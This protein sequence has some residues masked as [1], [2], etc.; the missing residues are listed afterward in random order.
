MHAPNEF[1]RLQSFDRGVR[2]Y[3]RLFE[4]LGALAPAALRA[5]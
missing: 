2:A 5:G 4:E 3:V 1:L